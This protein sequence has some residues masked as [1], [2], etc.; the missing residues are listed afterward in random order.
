[1]AAAAG[2]GFRQ[3]PRRGLAQRSAIAAL[4]QEL[5]IDILIHRDGHNDLTRTGIFA[6]RPAPVQVN[7]LGYPG[8]IGAPYIDYMIADR[9]LVPEENRRYF[10]EKIVYLPDSY[11]PNDSTR[12]ISD[13]TMSRDEFGLPDDAF[14]FCCFNN[15]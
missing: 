1:M 10:D 12:V 9:T 14:V 4:V 7:Y 5:E 2:A 8:T 3:L 15:N 13:R 6:L 11:Q